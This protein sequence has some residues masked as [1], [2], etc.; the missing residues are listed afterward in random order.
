MNAQ[1]LKVEKRRYG[2]QGKERACDPQISAIH[3]I[4]DVVG[5][6]SCDRPD[7]ERSGQ[8]GGHRQRGEKRLRRWMIAD[9]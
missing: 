2:G 1:R 3:V 5:G 6:R 8:D 7:D 4:G 9:Q